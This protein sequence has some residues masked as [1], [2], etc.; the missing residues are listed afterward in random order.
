LQDVGPL[1]GRRRRRTLEQEERESLRR[2]IGL[3]Q[4]PKAIDDDAG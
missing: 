1:A 3:L 4:V 2:L